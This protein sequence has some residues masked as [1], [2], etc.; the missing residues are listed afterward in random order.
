MGNPQRG[1]RNSEPACIC[2]SQFSVPRSGFHILFPVLRFVLHS[3]CRFTPRRAYEGRKTRPEPGTGKGNWERRAVT[4]NSEWNGESITW[5]GELGTSVF[6]ISIHLPPSA[7]ICGSPL[8]V[9]RCPS[10]ILFSVLRF[11]PRSE[12]RAILLLPEQKTRNGTGNAE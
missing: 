8:S 9:P 1:S 5:A 12:S 10:R 11:I 3:H 2:G 4:E 7:W 6:S